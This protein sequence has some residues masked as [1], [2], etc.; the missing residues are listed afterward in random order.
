MALIYLKKAEIQALNLRSNLATDACFRRRARGLDGFELN[1]Q[2]AVGTQALAP[3]EI[4]A[5]ICNDG[6]TSMS[7]DGKCD[8]LVQ[9]LAFFSRLMKPVRAPYTMER[10][11]EIFEEFLT[12][13]ISFPSPSGTVICCTVAFHC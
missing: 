6:V 1:E 13:P 5:V 11:A 9:F 12:Q 2:T 10:P 7:S 8:C 3:N 4:K